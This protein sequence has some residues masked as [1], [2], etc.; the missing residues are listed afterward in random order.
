[1]KN[2]SIGKLC[3]LHR[4]DNPKCC[5]PAHLFLGT[6]ADNTRD[7]DSKG[8][9]RSRFGEGH[10]HAKLTAAKVIEIR[11]LYAQGGKTHR[12]LADEFGVAA[13]VVTRIINRKSWR[14]V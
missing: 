11:R 8:R 10:P 5:N 2:G 1:M 12:A 3:V 9:R 6:V 4:C 7:M 14:A 13:P